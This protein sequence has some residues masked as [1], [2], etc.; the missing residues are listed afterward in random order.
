MAGLRRAM[1]CCRKAGGWL[2]VEVRKKRG[3][4]CRHRGTFLPRELCY[5]AVYAVACVCLRLPQV[6]VL[7]E[8]EKWLEAGLC[9]RHRNIARGLVG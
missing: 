2:R 7:L 9:K 5:R 4:A 1:T 3:S 6:G 8:T